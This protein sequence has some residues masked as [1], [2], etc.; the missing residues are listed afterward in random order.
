MKV[1]VNTFF[2]DSVA[3]VADIG[4]QSIVLIGNIVRKTFQLF[5]TPFAFLYHSLF[6]S[7]ASDPAINEVGENGYTRLQSAVRCGKVDQIDSLI[8]AGADVNALSGRGM[9]A[10]HLAARN[11]NV[12]I[13]K[14]LIGHGATVDVPDENGATPL[15]IAISIC[16]IEMVRYLVEKHADLECKDCDGNDALAIAVKINQTMAERVQSAQRQGFLAPGY[17][18]PS[19]EIIQILQP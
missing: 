7:V 10:L 6:G 13:A 9:T 1:T 3:R 15:H 18:H 17:R 11:G 8:E 14:A 19:I 4:Y 2:H 16:R 12:N 5:V